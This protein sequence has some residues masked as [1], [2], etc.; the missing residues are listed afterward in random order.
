[1]P[2]PDK[3]E[4][5]QGFLAMVGDDDPDTQAALAG[6]MGFGYR[7]SVGEAIF[8]LVIAQPDSGHSVTSLSQHNVRP[9]KFHYVDVC[10]LLK[11]LFVTRTD[12]IYYWR[13]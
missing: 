3:K 10:H 13:A 9:H 11:Y 5:L 6:E 1:M 2:L 7:S 4:F 12:G 8:V